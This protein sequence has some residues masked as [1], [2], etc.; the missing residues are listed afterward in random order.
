[1]KPLVSVIIPTYNRAKTIARTINSLLLQTYD[2]FEIIIVEDGSVDD[3]KSI[4]EQ[5]HDNRLR[6]I[7]HDVNKGVTA[8]KNTGLNNIRG[9]WFTILDSDDEIIPRAL[10][11]MMR[12]PLEMDSTINAITCNCIDTSNGSFSGKGFAS[13]QYINFITLIND[14]SGEFWGLTKTALLLNDRFNERL[15]GY[16]ST[17][18]LKINERANR[19]YIHQALRIYHTEGDDRVLKIPPSIKKMS[20]HYEALSD[21]EHYLETFK[22]YSPKNFARDCVLAVMYLMADRNKKYAGFYYD[23]LNSIN[24]FRLLKSV[25]FLSFHSNAFITKQLIKILSM[26]NIIN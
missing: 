24:G 8:A 9:E 23:H 6:V 14:C 5:F 13:D 18:W 12:I 2:N 1:M 10:E 21:E 22:K 20:N 25:S 7:F 15:G 26:T 3:T 19:Y 11:T 4:L 17:L 16:E